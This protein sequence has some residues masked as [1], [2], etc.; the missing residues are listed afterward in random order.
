MPL[1]PRIWHHLN[2]GHNSCLAVIASGGNPI[3]QRRFVQLDFEALKLR[4]I[5]LLEYHALSFCGLKSGGFKAAKWHWHF[6]ILLC[7]DQNS[8]RLAWSW[9]DQKICKDPFSL[10][11]VPRNL[12]WRH[13]FQAGLMRKGRKPENP[14]NSPWP[15]NQPGSEDG[16]N[17]GPSNFQYGA[18]PQR[19]PSDPMQGLGSGT[20]R[21]NSN[22]GPSGHIRSGPSQPPARPFYQGAR[23]SY[24]RSGGT[25]PQQGPFDARRGQ[26]PFPGHNLPSIGRPIPRVGSGPLQNEPRKE[27]V[28]E[29]S[30]LKSPYEEL[31]NCLASASQKTNSQVRLMVLS[32]SVPNICLPYPSWS[33]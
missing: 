24:P 26:V 7:H 31:T 32:N 28:V 16:P 2:H 12:T 1:I 14:R 8:D 5:W 27:S 25:L 21:P 6:L 4:V 30:S 20:G 11:L 9:I 33:F 18:R 22:L 23:P 10:K 17:S 19:T 3:L 29:T 15:P 13:K